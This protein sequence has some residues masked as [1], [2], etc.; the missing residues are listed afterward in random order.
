M[1]QKSSQV[2]GFAERTAHPIYDRSNL[3]NTLG[4]TAIGPPIGAFDGAEQVWSLGAWRSAGAVSGW[5]FPR[6]LTRNLCA[7]RHIGRADPARRAEI[8]ERRSSGSLFVADRRAA[9]AFSRRA[10][11]AGLRSY[12]GQ[13]RFA[14]C[15]PSIG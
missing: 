9:T 8:L 5:R 2:G 10:E 13:R 4:Q 12:D 7:L 3:E 11:D 14:P 1:A 15:P 6:G